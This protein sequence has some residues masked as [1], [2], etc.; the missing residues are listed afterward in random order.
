M[1]AC[2]PGTA[3][4]SSASSGLELPPSESIGVLPHLWTGATEEGLYLLVEPLTQQG[5]VGATVAEE[6]DLYR[7]TFGSPDG[8]TVLRVQVIGVDTAMPLG[9]VQAG[10]VRYLAI[11]DPPEDLSPQA[12][13]YWHAV[14]RGGQ[15]FVRVAESLQRVSYLVAAEAALPESKATLQWRRGDL[16]IDLQPRSW[17]ARQRRSFLEA[18]A[19][20]QDE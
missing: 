20:F 13:L 6:E 10:E 8:T 17:N 18:P 3:Q 19:A 14:H 9:Q 15:E 7:K 16:T 5:E 11:Q 2:G 12:R 4:D 1:P